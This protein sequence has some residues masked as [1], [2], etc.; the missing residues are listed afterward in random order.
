MK[1]MN[2]VGLRRPELTRHRMQSCS[3]TAHGHLAESSRNQRLPRKE[4][5]KTGSV[6]FLPKNYSRPQILIFDIVRPVVLFSVYGKE[7]RISVQAAGNSDPLAGHPF[8]VIRGQENRD[9]RN[10][11]GW[12]NRP[13]GVFDTICFTITSFLRAYSNQGLKLVSYYESAFYLYDS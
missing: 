4:K 8:R 3:P 10:I 1:R 13:S 12:P 2:S 6:R 5:L 11:F 7:I 9:P